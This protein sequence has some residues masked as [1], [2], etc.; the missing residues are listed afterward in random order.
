MPV[1]SGSLVA[2]PLRRISFAFDSA[3]AS[4][5]ASIRGSPRAQRSA[6]STERDL[7][8]PCAAGFTGATAIH[9]AW[10]IDRRPG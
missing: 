5:A 9:E 4:A 3:L 7:D 6:R 8:D 10:F 1:G 2:L